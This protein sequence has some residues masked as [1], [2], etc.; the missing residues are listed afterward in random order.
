VIRQVERDLGALLRQ[1][2]EFFVSINFAASDLTNP[3]VMDHLSRAI[4]DMGIPPANLHIEAT[5]RTFVHGDAARQQLQALRA[6]GVSISIDDFG[7]GYSSLAYLTRLDVN[8]LKIDKTFVDPIGTG[9]V[10]ASVIDH[11]IAMAQSLHLGMIAEGVE[12]E[13]QRDYL[14]Q[15]GVPMA[16]GWLFSRPLPARDLVEGWRRQTH[17]LPPPNGG[18]GGRGARA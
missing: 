11:I 8:C 3:V 5:E 4:H 14:L 13:A 7:T 2:P 10:T 17:P 12:T 9:A 15:R 1:Q 16:Q 18:R 6:L